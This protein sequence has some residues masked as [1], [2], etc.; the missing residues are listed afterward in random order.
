[1]ISRRTLALANY[2]IH[3]FNVSGRNLTHLKLQKLVYI[4][5]GWYLYALDRVLVEDEIEVWAYG[6]VITALYHQFKHYGKEPISIL[7]ERIKTDGITIVSEGCPELV[8]DIDY[9]TIKRVADIVI[10]KYGSLSGES[11]S[12]LCNR[13][14]TPWWQVKEESGYNSI[15]NNSVVKRYYT[16]LAEKIR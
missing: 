16:N 10:D 3:S 8:N 4:T 15:I 5:H 7:S 12:Y 11:L 13:K 9:D 1:M 14:K 2:I 6:P